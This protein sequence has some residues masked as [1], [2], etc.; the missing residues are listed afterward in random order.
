MNNPVDSLTSRNRSYEENLDSVMENGSI[1]KQSKMP[2]TE[3]DLGLTTRK[4]RRG[5][6]KEDVVAMPRGSKLGD[7]KF[8][9]VLDLPNEFYDATVEAQEAIYASELE[10]ARAQEQSNGEKLLAGLG[11][12]VAKTGA[13]FGKGLGYIGGGVAAIFTQDVDDI[14]NNAFVNA[15]ESM[16]EAAKEA[17]PVHARREVTN[18][19]LARQLWSP[20]FWATEAADG[21]GFMASSILLGGG[22]GAVSKGLGASKGLA[23]L[24][25]FLKVTEGGAKAE[26]AANTFINT[27]GQS[28]VESFAETD[29]A[30]KEFDEHWV[31]Q[32]DGYYQSQDG[33]IIN[34]EQ[35]DKLRG[36]LG[37][38]TFTYNMVVTA[39]PN[40]FTTKALFGSGGAS[41][42]IF[43]ELNIDTKSIQSMKEGLVNATKRGALIKTV[44]KQGATGS[45]AEGFQEASQFAIGEYEG[46]K[47]KMMT[48]DDLIDGLIDGYVKAFT[49]TEGLKSVFLGGLLGLGPGLVKGFKDR[50]SRLKRAT[51]LSKL[52][53]ENMIDLKQTFES[54]YK[55]DADG[56]LIEKDGEYVI[57]TERVM[58]DLEQGENDMNDDFLIAFAKDN[59]MTH[60]AKSIVTRKL[61]EKALPYFQIEGGQD[62]FNE[63]FKELTEVMGSDGKLMG[64]SSKEA[65]TE[66][67]N[68][69]VEVAKKEYDNIKNI[70]PRY[71]G[72]NIKDYAEKTSTPEAKQALEQFYNQMEAQG[73]LYGALLEL[74]KT[75]LKEI[76][77]KISDFK[78]T[79]LVPGV[80]EASPELDVKQK[81]ELEILR[82]TKAA[83]KKNIS[84]INANYEKIFDKK[85][86]QKAF[87]GFVE[88]ELDKQE[89]QETYEE[90]KAKQTE[91]GKR[92]RKDVEEKYGEAAQETFNKNKVRLKDKDGNIYA[93]L[94]MKSP[95]G[96]MEYYVMPVD[97]IGV[98][99]K[100]KAELLSQAKLEELGVSEKENIMSPEEFE[101]WKNQQRIIVMN[102][103]R[104]KRLTE[105]VTS[106]ENRRDKTL[107]SIE[108]KLDELTNLNQR[109]DYWKNQSEI[110]LSEISEEISKLEKL[111][112]D[113]QDELDSM[114]DY[115]NLIK[116]NITMLDA[117]RRDIIQAMEDNV[118]FDFSVKLQSIKDTY[119]K[120]GFTKDEELLGVSMDIVE[121]QIDNLTAMRDMMQDSLQGLYDFVAQNNEFKSLIASMEDDPEAL[122]N[123]VDFLNASPAIR[124]EYPDLFQEPENL[125]NTSINF[126]LLDIVM[127]DENIRKDF[128]KVIKDN[129]RSKVLLF[130]DRKQ[131]INDIAVQLRALDK[132]YKTLKRNEAFNRYADIISKNIGYM[133]T[134]YNLK[135]HKNIRMQYVEAG[136]GQNSLMEKR[137]EQEGDSTKDVEGTGPL[138]DNEYSTIVNVYED[139]SMAN[140]QPDPK[141]LQQASD[142]SDAMMHVDLNDLDRYSFKIMNNKQLAESGIVP[143]SDEQDDLY[144]M[145]MENGS[146][147]IGRSGIPIFTGVAHVETYFPTDAP[148]R[149]NIKTSPEYEAMEIRDTKNPIT[150]ENPYSFD[151]K[152]HST[153]ASVIDSII[154]KRRN[155]YRNWRDGL[156]NR[157][158]NGQ[159]I[160]L[161]VR[162]VSRGHAFKYGNEKN[163]PKRVF[164]IKSLEIGDKFTKTPNGQKI[165]VQNGAVYIETDTGQ[166]H[167]LLNHTIGSLPTSKRLEYLNRIIKF[168]ALADELGKDYNKQFRF[169]GSK[170]GKMPLFGN[171]KRPGIMD[172]F[173]SWN[174][175]KSPEWR[176]H[177]ETKPKT[178]E[179]IFVFNVKGEE[180]ILHMNDFFDAEGNIRTASDPKMI[181]LVQYLDTKYMNVVQKNLNKKA[182]IPK[183]WKRNAL[184]EVEMTYDYAESYNDYVLDN[185]LYTDIPEATDS[186]V[187]PQMVNQYATFG[188]EI[189]GKKVSMEK[190]RETTKDDAPTITYETVD[191]SAM[192]P[193]ATPVKQGED[194][195][196]KAIKEN[197]EKDSTM[198]VQEG[199][200]LLANL[201]AQNN[202]MSGKEGSQYLNEVMGQAPKVEEIKETKE[203]EEDCKPKSPF[204]KKRKLG[205]K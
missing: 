110:P 198:D 84:D 57:D 79:A 118:E 142:W 27:M 174:I 156:V 67:L 80:T 47:S 159:D 8:D 85:E 113:V 150:K 134:K 6:V 193:G 9:T 109:I 12:A 157:T 144:A 195:L 11:R 86:Q 40:Y 164:N 18:G 21:I 42:N 165:G 50:K 33:G 127:E 205:K 43:D 201:I 185:Y 38:S 88:R 203:K 98:A 55:K 128:L 117:M 136:Y 111:I 64:F 69:T 121:E 1:G 61:I 36:K 45:A 25:R 81:R 161:E 104:L 5:R 92:F 143:P 138:K 147:Y 132:K 63:H 162:H 180:K 148:A 139:A 37:A 93:V 177:M 19:S 90:E 160:N 173:I 112:D 129:T 145:L 91:F 194:V 32:G 72:I 53:E 106:Y 39:L 34:Q 46:A 65:Y 2:S 31:D 186:D 182:L 62:I 137:V 13:E 83:I 56:N 141:K 190:N 20:E 172:Y 167:R 153:K 3:P 200:S 73:A 116:D 15:F 54:Y 115:A 49:T 168:M 179:K 181:E 155:D 24:G 187:V 51:G 58:S 146:P 131:A 189:S 95:E 158:S 178:G 30:L 125:N 70:G 26:G 135:K 163:N 97:S 191:M 87:D 152:I 122:A 105:L 44:L 35:R 130:N 82:Q 202:A 66:Y 176:I 123:I 102:D 154:E 14:V 22:L 60:A 108:E 166:K 23:N 7:S 28:Y 17:M 48:D 199:N 175:K 140:L 89:M 151:G 192:I 16:D 101:T 68:K 184:G 120:E 78:I 71:F 99:R 133:K 149:I 76:D 188:E 196:L 107:V 74:N 103:V 10:E 204:D 59:G 124:A 100:S 96:A 170:K 94:K 52:M 171:A 126:E 75:E 183:D 77:A 29:G 114:Y 4:Q 169:K 119:E 197:Q 41:K